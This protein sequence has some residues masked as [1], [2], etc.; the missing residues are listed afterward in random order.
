MVSQAGLIYITEQIIVIIL[1]ILFFFGL[2]IVSSYIIK[3]LKRNRHNRLLNA[4]EYLPK[5]E[6]QT[7]KQVFYLIIITLCF[8][9]ILIRRL[10]QTFHFL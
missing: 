2:Y 10:L 8:V 3:Y 6:T 5:E 9:D 1:A 7:L 4:T